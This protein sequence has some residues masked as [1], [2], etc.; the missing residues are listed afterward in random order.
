MSFDDLTSMVAQ[1]A[2]A[3]GAGPDAD[4]RLASAEQAEFRVDLADYLFAAFVGL[5]IVTVCTPLRTLHA[6]L[7]WSL[8]AL[9][10]LATYRD[11]FLVAALAWLFH[12]LFAIARPPWARRSVAIAG[13]TLCLMLALYTYLSDVIYLIIRRPLTAGLLVAA[14]NLRAIQASAESIV[15]PGLVGALAVA[16]VWTVLIASILVGLAPEELTSLRKRF[17]SAAGLA[18]TVL[19]LFAAHACAVRWV[20]YSLF[21]FNPQWTLISSFFERHTPVITDAIPASYFDDFEPGGVRGRPGADSFTVGG[22]NPAAWPRPLNVVMVV[23]ESVGAERVQLYGAPFNNTPGLV[24]LARHGMVFRRAYASEA[25]TS[26]AYGALF[27]SVYPD[28]DWPSITQLAPAL[29]IPG[30]PA[31]LASHGYRTVF[32][33]SGQ[34]VFDREGDFLRNHG[35]QALMAEPRDY[36][37]PRDPELVTKTLKWIESDPNRPFFIT[38]WTHDTHHPYV[39]ASN[40]D[41]GVHDSKFNRYLNA[42]QA[43]D[44]LITELAAALQKKGLADRTLLVVLGDH[45]E[46]FGDHNQLIHGGSVYDEEVHIPLMIENPVLFPRAVVV[47]RVM[48]QVDIAP[49]LLALLGFAAPAAWQGANALGGRLPPR[50][51][52]FAGTGNLTFGL[53]EGNFKYI[54]NFPRQLSQLY[55]LATDPKEKNDLSSDPAYAQMIARDHLRLEAWVSFQN[56]YLERFEKSAGAGP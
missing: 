47:D 27:T 55:D 53:V 29:A 32:I 24:E 2:V 14:D 56:P 46:A 13:W 11:L 18:A 7:T 50:A 51:Y 10:P 25:E 16:P 23:M 39:S 4:D 43:T 34:I 17:Y 15:T 52:F 54:Y 21:S 48:R 33:H 12:G 45:G 6:L 19:Y 44:T 22:L 30:L 41:F 8:V 36:P 37:Y 35:F 1:S 49:T 9:L 20:P 5:A 28:H 3:P 42:V 31:V 40:R 38:L 26:A